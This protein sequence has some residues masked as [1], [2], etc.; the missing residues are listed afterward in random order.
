M[1][2]QESKAFE[3][4][5]LTIFSFDI[6]KKER[7]GFKGWQHL[8][9]RA[10]VLT[11]HLISLTPPIRTYPLPAFDGALFLSP[12]ERRPQGMGIRKADRSANVFLKD[13][14]LVPWRK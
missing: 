6:Q 14:T 11:S 1:A 10:I 13:G 5:C 7:K 8:G 2:S 3:S 12:R 4:I 9:L